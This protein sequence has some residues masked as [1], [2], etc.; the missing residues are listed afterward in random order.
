MTGA[1]QALLAGTLKGQR[2]RVLGQRTANVQ[3]QQRVA[4]QRTSAAF[5]HLLLS[6]EDVEH[7][8]DFQGLSGRRGPGSEFQRVRDVDVRSTIV[9]PGVSVA[10]VVEELFAVG[11][12]EGG[13]GTDY[14]WKDDCRCN[15]DEKAAC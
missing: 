5:L 10:E 4:C 13:L 1:G 6:I 11:L 14:Q 15:C 8:A 12:R 2:N 9:R 3:Y 7:R